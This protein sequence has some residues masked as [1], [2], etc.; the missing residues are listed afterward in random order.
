MMMTNKK[1]G[2]TGTANGAFSGFCGRRVK[3]IFSVKQLELITFTRRAEVG[4]AFCNIFS[5]RSRKYL[6][7]L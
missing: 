1:T 4:A 7:K 5:T 6:L 2:S 3:V